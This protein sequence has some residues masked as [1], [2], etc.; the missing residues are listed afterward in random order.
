MRLSTS[1]TN[2]TLRG[3]LDLLVARRIDHWRNNTG[4][5]RY[6]GNGK[7]RLVVFGI[8]GGA[9]VL[10]VLE[11]FGRWL[12]VETKAPAIPLLGRRKGQLSPAQ[13]AFLGSVI[14]RGGVGVAIWDVRVLEAVL[15][16]LRCDPLATFSIDGEH[17]GS[18]AEKARSL[19]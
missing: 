10:A 5:A 3:V 8:K 4:A 19:R 15:H 6:P 11:P 2:T 16:Q 1:E 17:T 14:G 13:R 18:L 12:A 9:D 7:P